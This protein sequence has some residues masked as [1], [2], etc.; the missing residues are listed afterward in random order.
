[1]FP[2]VRSWFRGGRAG[3]RFGGRDRDPGAGRARPR[4]EPLE[5]RALLAAAPLPAHPVKAAIIAMQDQVPPGITPPGVW[6]GAIQPT[7]TSPQGL[8]VKAP[9]ALWFQHPVATF[10]AATPPGFPPP[11]FSNFR[12]F[13]GWG[14][15]KVTAGFPVDTG[16]GSFQ[17]V[18]S[19]RYKHG[20]TFHTT[21]KILAWPPGTLLAETH[22]V[23]QASG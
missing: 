16:N 4:V 5:G 7:V 23:I 14:D 10:Q 18:S 8:F 22:G 3:G 11:S 15:G 6:T 21:I 1:M 2:S 12:A 17:V 13:V 20:G 9:A 19:H